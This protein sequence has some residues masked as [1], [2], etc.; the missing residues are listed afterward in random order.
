MD[1]TPAIPAGRKMITGYGGGGFKIN[2]EFI[3]GSLLV[4]GE[5]CVAWN[6]SQPTEITVASLEPILFQHGI[7]LLLIG[8]G[9]TIA[10]ID[11][12]IRTLLKSKNIALDV[13]DTGAACRTYNVLVGEDR[14]A[15]AA[16]IFI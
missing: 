2:G 14:M 9:E 8:T 12:A 13:M 16:L 11:P 3:A 10:P 5:K 15:A 4:F 6:I 7:E 1:I